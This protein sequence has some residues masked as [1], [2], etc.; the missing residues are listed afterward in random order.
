MTRPALRRLYTRT[1]TWIFDGLRLI[2][3]LRFTMKRDERD[4]T[5]YDAAREAIDEDGLAKVLALAADTE[6]PDD[7]AVAA[8]HAVATDTLLAD[9]LA[10]AAAAKWRGRNPTGDDVGEAAERRRSCCDDER[11]EGPM[12]LKILKGEW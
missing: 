9:A 8:L 4:Y 1:T 3:W 11:P 7:E 5:I 12:E 10:A 2:S 6:E